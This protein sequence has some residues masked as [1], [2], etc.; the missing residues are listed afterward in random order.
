[1]NRER[2]F[3]AGLALFAVSV[4]VLIMSIPSPVIIKI[5]GLALFALGMFIAADAFIRQL[6][7]A[8]H[9]SGLIVEYQSE[10]IKLQKQAA[11]LSLMLQLRDF[12]N[13]PAKAVAEIGRA[14]V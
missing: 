1:M 6:D 12:K 14:H 7:W 2:M 3:F 8:H 9:Q 5:I 4:V 10:R 11:D 13:T